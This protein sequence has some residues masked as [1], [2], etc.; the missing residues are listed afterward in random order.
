MSAQPNTK[1]PANGMAD[2]QASHDTRNIAIDK[3]GVKDVT[4][5]ITLHC[6]ATG[7]MQHTVANINM[8][9]GLPHYQKGT[10]MSRFLEVLNKHHE[11]LRSDEIM[12]VARDMMSKLE[13]EE[14]HLELEFPYFIHKKAPVTG[15][16]GMLNISVFFEATVSENDEPDTFVMGLKVPATSLCPCS[17]EISAYGAHNSVAKSLL[18]SASPKA[19]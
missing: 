1:T 19:R 3:V 8:Y 10:H 13:A 2:V 5:P 18:A 4:Y 15:S 7:G 12:N 6:P 14:A 17:K 16:P 9:V 11:Q